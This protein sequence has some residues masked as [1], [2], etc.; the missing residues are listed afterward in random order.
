MRLSDLLHSTVVDRDGHEVGSVEDV[1]LVQDGPLIEG[2]GAALR[3]EGLLIGGGTLSVRLGYHR[4]R[5]RGPV[6]LRAL[7]TALERR[8]HYAAWEQVA[9]HGEGTVQLRCPVSDLPRLHDLP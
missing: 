5:V 2:F 4:K 8:A 3:V 1:R 7:F 9:S 6:L